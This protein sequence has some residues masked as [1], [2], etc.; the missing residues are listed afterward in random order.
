M[1][2]PTTLPTALFTAVIRIGFELANH[3]FIEPQ[4][5]STINESFD[6]SSVESSSISG[7]I[8]LVKED[9]VTSEQTFLVNIKVFSPHDSFQPATLNVDYV[10]NNTSNLAKLT[11]K[12]KPTDQRIN[13]PFT[14]LPDELVE[15]TEAFLA[16]SSSETTVNSTQPRYEIPIKLFRETLV[17]IEDDDIPRKNLKQKQ[18]QNFS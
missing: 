1:F 17:I 11:L 9:N 8:F 5:R 4:F 12:F 13:F 2:L 18:H 7:P 10:L 14:L 3:T 16:R 15:G 6:A